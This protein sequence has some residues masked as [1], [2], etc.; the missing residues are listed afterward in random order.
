MIKK[1]LMEKKELRQA[2]RSYKKSKESDVHQHGRQEIIK[3]MADNLTSCNF[4]Y[5]IIVKSTM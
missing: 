5:K 3:A 4:N 1:T 2:K